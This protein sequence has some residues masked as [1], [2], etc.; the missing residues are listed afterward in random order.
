LGL[1]AGAAFEGTI[2]HRQI[3]IT[4]PG[5][6]KQDVAKAEIWIKAGLIGQGMHLPV[7]W[8]INEKDIRIK[9]RRTP[10]QPVAMPD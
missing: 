3:G 6:T 9:W 4:H 10:T 5:E 1:G 8:D 7:N 2:A